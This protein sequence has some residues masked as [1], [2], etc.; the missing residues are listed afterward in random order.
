MQARASPVRKQHALEERV[1]LGVLLDTFVFNPEGTNVAVSGV[2]LALASGVVALRANYVLFIG[3]EPA[4]ADMC[5]AKG[6]AGIKSCMRCA[7]LVLCR[8]FDEGRDA[9]TNVRSTETEFNKFE[10]LTVPRLRMMLQRLKDMRPLL[11]RTKFSDLETR[12]GFNHSDFNL[13]MKPYAQFPKSM[14]FDWMHL[15][16]VGGL[17]PQ[18]FGMCMRALRRSNAPTKI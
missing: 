3:D 15:Y 6:H 8:Y 14:M 18:E 17:L 12:F 10:P 5:L 4:L 2:A 7:N 16:M 9:P 1:L 13:A 11:S